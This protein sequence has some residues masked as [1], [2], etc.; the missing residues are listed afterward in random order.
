MAHSKDE[1]DPSGPSNPLAPNAP[2]QTVELICFR[3]FASIIRLPDTDRLT[4]KNR[5]DW[6]EAITQIFMTCNIVGY[7]KG[8]IKCPSKT[9]D[10]IGSRPWV[11]NDSWVQSLIMN[12][13]MPSQR[14]HTC[15]KKPAEECYTALYNIHENR[16]NQSV[17][18]VYNLLFT[19]IAQENDNIPDHLDLLKSN[20]TES[21]IL[22][23]GLYMF[24]AIN[25]RQSSPLCS[26]THGNPLW[27]LMELISMTTGTVKIPRRI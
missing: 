17:N 25:L 1:G 7:I 12:N 15:S 26:L 9:V 2:I 10:A 18:Q 24:M 11:Q 19:T 27:N 22:V 20:K 5:F 23:I 4:H 21:T 8:T 3:D 14:S 16:G 13:I 6:K